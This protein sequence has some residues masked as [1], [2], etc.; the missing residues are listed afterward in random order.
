MGDGVSGGRPV[1]ALLR[2]RAALAAS[3]APRPARAAARRPRPEAVTVRA[4]GMR[5]VRGRLA[6]GPLLLRCALGRAGRKV[7]K[8]EGDG[9]SAVG[10]FRV[11]FGFYRPDRMG[12]P[13]T[14]LPMVPLAPGLGW[15]DAPDHR[16]YNRQVALP[17]AASHE[18][19]WRGDAL[20]DVV[21]VPD[22]N[23]LSPVPGRGSALFVHLARPGHRPTEGCVALSARD[24]RLLLARL[25]PGSVLTV[26]G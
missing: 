2:A 19:M 23:V 1:G 10:R 3:R 18:E 14:G 7:A 16:A 12:R 20:Y 26:A 21:L 9:A 15:C 11:L 5:A 25:S 8:R 13:R 17:L 4:T 6:C 22:A 24:M